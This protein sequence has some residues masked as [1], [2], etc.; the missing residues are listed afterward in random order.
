MIKIKEW[1][2]NVAGI[3]YKDEEELKEMF[4][5]DCFEFYEEIELNGA[6]VVTS[7]MI[8]DQVSGLYNSYLNHNDLEK[9]C[10]LWADWVDTY[11]GD[12]EEF[13]LWC[14]DYDYTEFGCLVD[15]KDYDSFET[16]DLLGQHEIIGNF[17]NKNIG[18][19]TTFF[20]NFGTNEVFTYAEVR[21]E[22]DAR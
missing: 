19:W 4:E 7:E 6:G 14:C 17:I 12:S 16:L 9:M 13:D 22:Y 8:S 11:R 2:M 5:Q 3:Y 18:E 21:K 10:D 20:V 15:L 1:N